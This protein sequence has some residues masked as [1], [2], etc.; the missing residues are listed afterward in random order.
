MRRLALAVF[1][2]VFLAACQPNT[3]ELTEEQRAELTA[4]VSAINS[5]F[6]DVWREADVARGMSYYKD[7]PDFVLAISGQ[8]IRGFS[9][10]NDMA[11]A[12]FANVESQTITIDDSQ[13]TVLGPNAAVV[14][15][16]VTYTQTDTE[17]V[18]GPEYTAAITSI[19][20]RHEGEWKVGHFHNSSPVPQ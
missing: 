20:V 18:T 1:S 14:V 12:V 17:G 5:E 9:E 4:E 13:T 15:E 6:W 10:F 16:H 7:S 19:W 3:T 8:L 11:A 2:L